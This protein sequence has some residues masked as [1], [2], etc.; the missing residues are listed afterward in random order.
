M[1][2]SL[3]EQKYDYYRI[4][5]EDSN[6]PKSY[7]AE[8]FFDEEFLNYILERDVQYYF[9]SEHL[10]ELFKNSSSLSNLQKKLIKF[11]FSKRVIVYGDYLSVI[12][13]NVELKKSFINEVITLIKNGLLIKEN[14]LN[15][16]ALDY[17]IVLMFFGENDIDFKLYKRILNAVSKDYLIRLIN[18]G[19]CTEVLSKLNYRELFDLVRRHNVFNETKDIINK[20]IDYMSYSEIIDILINYYDDYKGEPEIF[21][22]IYISYAGEVKREKI[23]KYIL[24]IHSGSSE[25]D[26]NRANDLIQTKLGRDVFLSSFLEPTF[27]K[28]ASVLKIDESIKDE[29]KKLL[30]SYLS[31]YKDFSLDGIRNLYCIYYY[32]QIPYNVILDLKTIL[33]YAKMD[34]RALSLCGGNY[35]K[36]EN[37]FNFLTQDDFEN[38]EEIIGYD[39]INLKDLLNNMFTLFKDNLSVEVNRENDIID[40]K[41]VLS[42]N[43]VPVTIETINA[44]IDS[45]YLT[46]STTVND[47]DVDDYKSKY[48]KESS[49]HKKICTSLMGM[50]RFKSFSSSLNSVVFGYCNFGDLEI[51]CVTNHDGQTNQRY[52]A[53]CKSFLST[54]RDLIL[55]TQTSGYNEINFITDGENVLFPSYVMCKDREPNEKEIEIAAQF[56]IPIRIVKVFDKE[57]EMNDVVVTSEWY[58]ENVTSV[59][60]QPSGFERIEKK[61]DTTF[62]HM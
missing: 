54:P 36:L 46:H 44:S 51:Y 57:I 22:E 49:K 52:G 2:K 14:Y 18:D 53:V 39:F 19:I 27:S 55:N 8:M 59:C 28:I 62:Y 61:E 42:K 37:I 29:R 26:I 30:E 1:E 12:F 4:A 41:V 7:T 58:E 10:I 6:L 21:N 33:Y 25:D 13:T 40:S 32:E 20:K 31:N 23:R 45:C 56:S 3:L 43:N 34:E 38:I 60:I 47:S 50:N 15:F 17:D 5:Y 48:I 9:Y 16:F 11:L 35:F 24:S